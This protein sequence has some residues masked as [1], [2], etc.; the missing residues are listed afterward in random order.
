MKYR[1]SLKFWMVAYRRCYQI[2]AHLASIS[3]QVCILTYYSNA[4]NPVIFIIPQLDK[5][6][7]REHHQPVPC[8]LHN[9]HKLE[10]TRRFHLVNRI[11]PP[12]PVDTPLY[13]QPEGLVVLHAAI[14][15]LN[16][17]H[18]AL[19]KQ[20]RTFKY[21]KLFSTERENSISLQCCNQ[22]NGAD[23]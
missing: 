23:V 7:P 6:T 20:L 1:T 12:L 13:Q 4:N 2:L 19:I 18:Q 3:L 21:W 10:C 16:K 15:E 22:A 8:H 17:L 5:L 14:K 9:P 11:L